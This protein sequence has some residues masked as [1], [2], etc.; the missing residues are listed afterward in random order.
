MKKIKNWCKKIFSKKVILVTHSG[1]F[2]ADDIFATVCLIL[3][4]EKKNKR[5]KIIRT[6]DEHI[7]RKYQKQAQEKKNEVFV[8]DVGGKYNPEYN[9]FDHHQKDFDEKRQE[10]FLY[11]SVG[12]V[13][14]KF[15][16]EICGGDE[17]ISHKIDNDFIKPIDATDNG[18]KIRDDR[19]DFYL[20]DLANLIDF[21]GYDC[22]TN[23]MWDT[24]FQKTLVFA[25]KILE[26]KILKENKKKEHQ[27]AFEKIYQKSENKKNC[28]N[29]A[30]FDHFKIPAKLSRS[31]FFGQK[32]SRW[33]MKYGC[34][35]EAKK[36]FWFQSLFSTRMVWIEWRSIWESFR[37]YRCEF[38]S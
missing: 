37:Y 13:W 32:R 24:K 22:T 38:L 33:F 31:S 4:L 5:W 10:G 28:M 14:K 21:F 19:Y 3:F 35:F 20:Y 7:L 34:Y 25:K 27:E 8:Y 1:R 9:W 16:L 12:L 23:N 29:R 17:K 6:R 36:F 18:V 26:K 2:H 11:S 30:R 15:G